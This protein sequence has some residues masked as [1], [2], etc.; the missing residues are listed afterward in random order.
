VQSLQNFPAR[1]YFRRAFFDQ[2]NLILL[3]GAAVLSL[4]FASPLPALIGAGAEVLFLLIA[5]KLEA[6]R[7]FVDRQDSALRKQRL[8][9]SLSVDVA[10]LGP[11]YAPRFEAFSR[12][13]DEMVAHSVAR[14]ALSFDEL[15][16]V[17]EHFEQLLRSLLELMLA[18]QS[19]LVAIAEI[20][21]LELAQ[22]VARLDRAFT[23][24]RDLEARMGLR[25]QLLAAQKRLTQ[26][27]ELEKAG[28][29]LELELSTLEK[30]VGTLRTRAAELVASGQLLNEVRGLVSEAA[31]ISRIELSGHGAS[32]ALSAP[33]GLLR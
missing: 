15:D 9:R 25:Q 16:S 33:P 7:V 26:R 2:H 14:R 22:E 18:H 8:V 31:P 3:A 12:A 1:S 17:Q 6:F 28:G 19:V 23:G 27:E 5:P 4:A 13:L 10:S 32:P 21:A 24:Q 11:G 30:S 20:P 29:K